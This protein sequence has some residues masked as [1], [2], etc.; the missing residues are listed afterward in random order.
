MNSKRGCFFRAGRGGGVEILADQLTLSELGS[1]DSAHHITTPP[2]DLK[3]T[4][5][6]V[7]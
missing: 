7:I 1:A 4:A 5:I 3:A 2:P 6:P